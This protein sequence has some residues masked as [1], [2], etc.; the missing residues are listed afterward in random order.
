MDEFVVKYTVTVCDLRYNYALLQ[1]NGMNR[2][3]SRGESLASVNKH[4]NL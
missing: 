4:P 1:K 2:T 3:E